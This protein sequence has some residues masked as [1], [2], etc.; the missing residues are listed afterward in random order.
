M[1]RYAKV[2]KWCADCLHFYQNFVSQSIS[3]KKREIFSL[4]G[5]IQTKCSS[6]KYNGSEW[7]L[8]RYEIDLYHTARTTWKI[9]KLNYNENLH[10]TLFWKSYAHGNFF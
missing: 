2:G 1:Y 7:N 6:S 8:I 5:L 9:F 4:L 10:S 3:K